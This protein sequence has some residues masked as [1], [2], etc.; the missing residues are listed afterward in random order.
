[1]GDPLLIHC[2]QELGFHSQTET[3]R[4][5]VACGLWAVGRA[6]GCAADCAAGCTTEPLCVTTD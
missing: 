5:G 2:G 4:E 6:M 1:M 3:Q